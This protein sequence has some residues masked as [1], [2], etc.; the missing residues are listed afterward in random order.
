MSS[1]QVNVTVPALPIIAGATVQAAL[2]AGGLR[3]KG[4]VATYPPANRRPQGFISDRQRRGF[5]AL[6]RSGAIEVPYRRGLSPNSEGLGRRWTAQMQGNNTVIVG[7]NASYAPL[8]QGN[9]RTQYHRVTGWKTLQQAW[10]EN[11]AE[12]AREIKNAIGTAYR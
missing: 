11:G 2:L 8:V 5:F 7:N 6:L 9:S 10:Q 4:I 3:F 1:L 12:V